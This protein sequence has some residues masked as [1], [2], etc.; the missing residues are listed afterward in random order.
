MSNSKQIIPLLIVISGIAL[1][2]FQPE[3]EVVN[4]DKPKD[5]PPKRR[6]KYLD[7]LPTSTEWSQHQEFN[8]FNK[9][10]FGKADF[11]H[12]HP[13][14]FIKIFKEHPPLPPLKIKYPIHL[15]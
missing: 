8:P 14:D 9:I 10:Y 1:Y 5:E 13:P 6:K 7:H 11:S 2:A 3:T 4:I 15:S 12:I